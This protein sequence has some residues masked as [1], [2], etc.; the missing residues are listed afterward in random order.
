MKT[1][2]PLDLG[3]WQMLTATLQRRQ[4]TLYKDGERIGKE[5][6]GLPRT[7]TGV[8][9]GATDP[10]TH[11]HAFAGSVKNFTIRRGALNDGEVKKLF[12]QHEAA[13]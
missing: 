5:R 2:S 9:V 1:N 3:R 8:S 7:R 4:P 10:W 12:D 11:Q 13:P 6:V